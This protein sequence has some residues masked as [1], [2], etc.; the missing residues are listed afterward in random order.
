MRSIGQRYDT[1]APDGDTDSAS[2]TRVFTLFVPRHITSAITRHPCA[3]AGRGGARERLDAVLTTHSLDSIVEMVVTGAGATVSNV[4]GMTGTKAG[5]S[6]QNAAMEV[7]WCGLLPSLHLS[8]HQLDKTDTPPI[9]EAYIPPRCPMSRLALR[10]PR[11]LHGSP[12]QHPRRISG[13]RART[14]R[15]RPVDATQIRGRLCGPAE[16]ARDA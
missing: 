8:P 6:L 2:G 15:A 13:A 14:R 16:S 9:P 7:K 5:L 10:R 12:L 11:R 4:V 1:L 3:N